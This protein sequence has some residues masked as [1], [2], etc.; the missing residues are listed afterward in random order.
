MPRIPYI[1][2]NF[3]KDAQEIIT[4]SNKIIDGYLRQGI[5]LTLRQ[6][7][8]QFVARDEFPDDRRWT[9][10]GRRWVRDPKGT[11]NADPNYKWLGS[12][13]ND[14]RMAGLIDWK[15]IIDRTRELKHLTTWESPEEIIQNSIDYYRI[16]KWKYQ[17][18]R[19]EVWIEKDALIGVIMGVCNEL[20]VPYF[21]C[22]GYVSQ[23]E[24]WE[25]G[26]RMKDYSREDKIPFIIHLGDHDPSGIDMSRDIK[27]RIALFSG[28]EFEFKRI[29]L[30]MNQIKHFN[31]P[32]NPAKI[33][34]HRSSGYIDDYGNES[35]ELDAIEPVIMANLIRSIVLEIRNEARWKI[36]I[37][38]ENYDKRRMEDLMDNLGGRND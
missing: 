6:L 15:S 17:E 3:R 1:N 8:Y 12:I 25:S 4:K 21:S 30:N 13:V 32:P 5:D 14:G 37:E 35:W 23:S 2:K 19:P 36:A 31:P 26:M 34:D 33:T 9:W 7:Y 20:E 27:D 29:A 22:R 16:D 24:M 10:T 28:T 18:Y 38:E 11:K